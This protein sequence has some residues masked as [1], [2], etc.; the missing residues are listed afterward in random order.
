MN[1]MQDLMFG[2]DAMSPVEIE[3]KLKRL[4]VQKQRWIAGFH[5][6]SAVRHLAFNVSGVHVGAKTFI[7]IGMVVLDGYQHIVRIG[8][9]GSIGNGVSLTASASPN[10][11]VLAHHPG[12]QSAIKT[13]PITIGDDVW[14]G[15]GAI[16][17]PG[18][19]VGYAAVI[20]AGAVVT[21][22]VLPFQIVQ[23]VPARVT[24]TLS[25]T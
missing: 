15:T 5:P 9:R 18:I 10:D 4:V 14:I 12:L 3:Q 2:S 25:L 17:L 22:D 13:A 1:D 21:K 23:G 7:S 6:N 20:G 16:I 8:E 11:S 19:T 24:R